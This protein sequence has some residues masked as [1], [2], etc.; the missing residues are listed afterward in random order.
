MKDH[1]IYLNMYSMYKSALKYLSLTSYHFVMLKLLLRHA[2]PIVTLQCS[3]TPELH[4][5]V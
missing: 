3:T 5:P 4:S 2:E 1:V